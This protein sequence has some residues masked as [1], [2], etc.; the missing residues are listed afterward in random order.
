MSGRFDR[1]G[2]KGLDCDS[3]NPHAWQPVQLLLESD[4]QQPD[5][6]HGKCFVAC[7]NCATWSYIELEWAGYRLNDPRN[8]FVESDD[9]D[10]EAK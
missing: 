10:G 8:P 6:T 7:M 4:G 1:L 9:E 2:L 3:G 5:L